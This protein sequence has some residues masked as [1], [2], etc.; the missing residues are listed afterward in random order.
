M[1]I[2]RR[3]VEG[4]FA[5]ARFFAAGGRRGIEFSYHIEVRTLNARRLLRE[6]SPRLEGAMEGGAWGIF[7]K[8][9]GN[10]PLCSK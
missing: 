9:F 3:V 10:S 2:L 8:C 7:A 5:N 4:G 6:K 1:V